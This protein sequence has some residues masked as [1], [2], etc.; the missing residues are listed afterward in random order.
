[1]SLLRRSSAKFLLLLRFC[2]RNS[3]PARSGAFLDA[4]FPVYVFAAW[5]WTL[6]GFPKL[7]RLRVDTTSSFRK[8]RLFTRLQAL[9]FWRSWPETS[10]SGKQADPQKTQS[11]TWYAISVP[12]LNF[13]REIS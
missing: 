1:M 9:D 5:P 4:Q 7:V 10:G 3:M 11:C 6:A 12:G 13:I 8:Q 2:L